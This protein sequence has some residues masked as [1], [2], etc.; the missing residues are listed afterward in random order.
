MRKKITVTGKSARRIEVTGKPKR[1]IEPEQFA[2][3][4]GAESIGVAHGPGMDPIA[5]A[6]LGSELYK[7]LRS[8]GGRPALTDAN[9]ICRVPLSSE[10]LKALEKIT[11]QIAQKSGMKPSPG[12]VASTIVREYLTCGGVKAQEAASFPGKKATWPESCNG[13][14]EKYR[15]AQQVIERRGTTWGTREA[16]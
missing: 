9:E 2:N 10:D 14:R 16:A 3:A 12:Q 11:E 1:R 6:A 15:S 4:L 5:V 7:R 8:S 13:N